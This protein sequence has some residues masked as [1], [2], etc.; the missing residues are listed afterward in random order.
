M[1]KIEA[2]TLVKVMA[3]I[4]VLSLVALIVVIATRTQDRP[5]YND[6]YV[7]YGSNQKDFDA[8]KD[9]FKIREN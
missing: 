3:I 6:E 9:C 4:T 8:R 7:C 2:W 1:V 5:T